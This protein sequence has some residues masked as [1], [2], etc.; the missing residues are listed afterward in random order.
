MN[1]AF[2]YTVAVEPFEGVM[3][4]GVKFPEFAPV[5]INISTVV[6]PI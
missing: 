1:V 4:A 2:P 6:K 3:K 5:L